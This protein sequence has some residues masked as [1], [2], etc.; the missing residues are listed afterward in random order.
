MPADWQQRIARH[1]AALGTPVVLE[2]FEHR[3]HGLART[4]LKIAALEYLLRQTAHRLVVV[5]RVHPALFADCGHARES[6]TEK[7]KH[8]II[9]Q[10][11]DR[12]LDA[13]ADFDIT[14]VL[15]QLGVPLLPCAP[16]HDRP[17]E[18]QLFQAEKQAFL[19]KLARTAKAGAPAPDH[20][21]R[22]DFLRLRWFVK[23][24]C[25]ALPFLS[26]PMEARLEKLLLESYGRGRLL[27]EDDLILC[28]QR[29]AEFLFRQLWETLTPHEHYVLYDLAQ[30][31]LLNGRDTLVIYDLLRK[32]L[33]IYDQA[34][35]RLVSESFRGFVLTG[36]PPQHAPRIEREA[37]QEATREGAWASRSFPIFLLLA[38]ALFLFVTQRGALSQAQTFLTALTA[39]LPLLYRFL[40]FTPFSGGAAAAGGKS[41]AA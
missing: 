15:M 16:W 29:Q 2:Y 24:E 30:D 5:S 1:P 27:R 12:L 4:E 41:G 6:C 20:A 7:D 10:T 19:R 35:P 21:L 14:Y 40:S 26:A 39:T 28:I 25:A 22:P 31:G 33:L 36:L 37:E 11:G 34:G 17:H 8:A 3:P 18:K 32:G 9:W 13:L 23:A 38:A